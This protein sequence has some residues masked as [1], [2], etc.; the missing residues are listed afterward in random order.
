M[1][2]FVFSLRIFEFLFS[3]FLFFFFPF[4]P[5]PVICA[6]AC[7]MGIY[8]CCLSRFENWCGV[9]FVH[10]ADAAALYSAIY[11]LLF[12]I[13][14]LASEMSCGKTIH[15]AYIHFIRVE[16]CRYG[17]QLLTVL[18]AMSLLHSCSYFRSTN[19]HITI[20][21]QKSSQAISGNI[22]DIS[23]TRD[24]LQCIC[25]NSVGRN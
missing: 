20:H 18:L 9:R 5:K 21:K 11:T 22:C 3:L 6:Y 4:S 7:T 17:C 12:L 13:H 14:L 10:I 2:T 8:Y 25:A 1:D 15:M 24:Q 23:H 19:V 16:C